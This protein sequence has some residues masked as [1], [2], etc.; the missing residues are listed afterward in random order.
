MTFGMADSGSFNINTLKSVIKGSVV[1]NV[2]IEELCEQKK[3]CELVLYTENQVLVLCFM[4]NDGGEA[5]S[6]VDF[7]CN[8]SEPCQRAPNTNT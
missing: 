1:F 2:L 4:K 7:M 6:D 5:L 8:L 3:L